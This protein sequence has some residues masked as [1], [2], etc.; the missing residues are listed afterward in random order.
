MF[1][2][3]GGPGA[4]SLFGLLEEFGPALLTTDSLDDNYKKTGVPTPQ[5]NEWAWTNHHT[6]CALDSPPPMGLSFCSEVNHLCISAS[7][8]VRQAGSVTTYC[9]E[10]NAD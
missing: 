10:C 4:S 6:V 9:I 2:Y 3:N 7:Q 5:S 1:W 8:S